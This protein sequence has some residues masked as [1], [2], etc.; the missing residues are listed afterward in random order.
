MRK[1]TH[2]L[3]HELNQ[4]CCAIRVCKVSANSIILLSKLAV[5]CAPQY[6]RFT[7]TCILLQTHIHVQKLPVNRKP[8]ASFKLPLIGIVNRSTELDSETW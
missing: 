6:E 4:L 5:Q 3:I 7:D 8:L 2:N 1:P